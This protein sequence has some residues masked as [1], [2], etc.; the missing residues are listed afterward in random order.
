M[1]LAANFP[2]LI[3]DPGGPGGG[4]GPTNMMNGE[5][6][7]ARYPSY[8]DPTGAAGALQYLRMAAVYGNIPKDP[9]LLRK[10]IE[11]VIGGKIEGAFKENKGMAYVLKVRNPDQ[12]RRLLSMSKLADGTEIQIAEH[13]TMN[14]RLC[15]VSNADVTD[16][17][18]DYLAAQLAPQGVKAVRRIRRKN[19]SGDW[20]NTPTIILT[21]SG[22][23][24]PPHVDFGWSR[25]R[26]RNYY[27]SPMLCFHCW[28]YGHT[29]KRC[30]QPTRTCGRCSKTHTTESNNLADIPLEGDRTSKTD[31]LK[32]TAE[33][34]VQ[35]TDAAF[36]KHCKANDHS[37]SSRKCPLYLRE[38]EIQRIR[39]DEGVSY[40]QARRISE[41]RTNA[42]SSRGAYS[43]SVTA[44]K[45]DEII[46]LKRDNGRLEANSKAM[47]KRLQEME[48]ALNSGHMTQRLEVTRNHGTIEDLIRQV[49]K[50]T[51]TVE[52]LEKALANKDAIIAKKDAE[53][54]KLRENRPKR[55]VSP[56]S[57]IDES[58]SDENI[59]ANQ[60]SVDSEV[61]IQMAN[62]C[63]T[64]SE[65]DP[66]NSNGEDSDREMNGVSVDACESRTTPTS[67]IT[68]PS[69]N[70]KRT[71]E[72]TG[73]STDSS[74]G[75]SE[76]KRNPKSRKGKS[77]NRN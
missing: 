42:T 10:S 17:S 44:S 30:Q 37:V 73:S 22:T 43:G 45:D 40:P 29:G 61:T 7:G 11:S 21:I 5:Y 51:A 63:E 53:L 12:F 77:G 57:L 76:A 46:A 64:T 9:F 33:P 55:V 8:M 38:V 65:K 36:C 4:T 71:L 14:Q 25:C 52:R 68:D 23:V 19:A 2:P 6:T 58:S 56:I 24:I 48:K 49:T 54:A 62:W 32:Q 1:A 35:C 16:L 70:G 60:L 18:D 72:K 15:V 66:L 28:E 50:L 75:P 69:N 34:N 59:N 74:S 31:T 3:G 20:E 13:P 27:P 41:A 26:T 47:E 67:A 39:V